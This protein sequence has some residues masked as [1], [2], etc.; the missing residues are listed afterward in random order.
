[1]IRQN[2]NGSPQ[3]WAKPPWRKEGSA[4]PLYGAAPTFPK[5]RACVPEKGPTFLKM[6]AMPMLLLNLAVVGWT[7][8]T[9]NSVQGLM[10]YLGY[11]LIVAIGLRLY[12]VYLDHSLFRTSSVQS[13]QKM[14]RSTRD[15][16]HHYQSE[17]WQDAP[18]N[19]AEH[20]PERRQPG[21]RRAEVFI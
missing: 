5:R 17:R 7:L 21:Q 6:Y 8:V 9:R 12:L 3:L 1:M 10:V 18:R 11:A 4:V 2:E 15:Q 20:G 16:N 19:S 14:Q 13:V